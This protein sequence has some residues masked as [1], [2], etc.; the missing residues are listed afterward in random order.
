MR[1]SILS[2]LFVCLV[3]IACDKDETAS[4]LLL[5]SIYINSE[6]VNPDGSLVSDVTITPIIRLTF[7]EA[8]DEATIISGVQ[9]WNNQQEIGLNHAL[10]S[11]NKTVSVTP[12]NKL[13]TSTE[14]LLRI[15]DELKSIG[16]RS[17]ENQELRFRTVQGEMKL[18]SIIINGTDVLNE[19]MIT[20]VP[21]TLKITLQFSEPV[22]RS[23]FQNALHITG[24]N[25]PNLSFVYSDNDQTI[26]VT[27]A[28]E[29]RYLSKYDFTI[30]KSLESVD[31]AI[32]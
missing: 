8:I 21:L 30:Q 22:N 25:V 2:L 24:N 31:G 4:P 11:D 32:F 18:Q 28:A 23:S 20:D 1:Y 9:L 27:S 7:S 14:Y 29:L 15:N 6:S 5:E 13:K 12:V 26:Q 17:F 16:G 3:L 10:S 19:N